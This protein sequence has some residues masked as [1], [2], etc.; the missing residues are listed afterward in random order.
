MNED[1][2]KSAIALGIFIITGEM[3]LETIAAERTRPNPA[4]PYVWAVLG[5]AAA[6][7]LFGFFW[8]RARGKRH[9]TN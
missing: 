6:L 4:S 5:I 1:Q 2:R 3:L 8:F 7:S 9:P